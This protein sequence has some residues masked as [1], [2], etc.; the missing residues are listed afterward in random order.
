[1]KQ[2]SFL[3]VALAALPLTS[4]QAFTNSAQRWGAHTASEQRLAKLDQACRT[5]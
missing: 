1:M 2:P 4:A 5:G 3:A